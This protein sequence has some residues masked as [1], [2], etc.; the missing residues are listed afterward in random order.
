MDNLKFRLGLELI[1]ELRSQC[2][3]TELGEKK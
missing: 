3:K 2:F 1:P